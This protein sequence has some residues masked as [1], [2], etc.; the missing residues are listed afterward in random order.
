MKSNKLC[1]VLS[2]VFGVTLL[3]SAGFAQDEQ[4]QVSVQRFQAARSRQFK[5]GAESP[6]KKKYLKDFNSL[7]YFGIDSKHR[8]TARFTPAADQTPF[9]MPT[10]YDNKPVK[11]IKRGTLQFNLNG[12]DYLL[13]VYQRAP[14]I[15]GKEIIERNYAFVPFRDLTN[16]TDTYDGGRYIDLARRVPETVTLDFNV[17]YTPDCA[18]DKRFICPIPPEENRID[19]RVEAGEKIYAPAL[20]QKAKK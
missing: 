16:G 11:H 8:V 15:G 9:E 18:Y 12:K 20:D 13:G 10:F 1:W 14:Q 17:A 19:A 6:L 5:T 4:Y 3:S 7:S 2:L